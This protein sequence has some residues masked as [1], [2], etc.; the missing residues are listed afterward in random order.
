MHARASLWSAKESDS[1]A[2]SLHYACIL[3]ALPSHQRSYGE[4]TRSSSLLVRPK[5]K[6]KRLHILSLLSKMENGVLYNRCVSSATH[7]SRTWFG[8][9]VMIVVAVLLSGEFPSVTPYS[10]SAASAVAASPGGHAGCLAR[11]RGRCGRIWARCERVRKCVRNVRGRAYG[12]R[13]LAARSVCY[14]KEPPPSSLTSR[15]KLWVF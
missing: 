2:P 4:E 9:N 12:K 13:F 5:E 14:G 6:R 15:G 11:G 8:H 7:V 1:I 10:H 3:A